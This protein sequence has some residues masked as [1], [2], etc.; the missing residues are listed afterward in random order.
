MANG[1]KRTAKT[2]ETGGIK[3]SPL[4]N[5]IDYESVNFRNAAIR[6]LTESKPITGRT[7]GKYRRAKQSPPATGKRMRVNQSTAATGKRS[8]SSMNYGLSPKGQ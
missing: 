4:I 6:R 7:S 3:K 2:I 5:P 8:S 1:N